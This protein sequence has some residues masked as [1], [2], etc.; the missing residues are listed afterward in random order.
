MPSHAAEAVSVGQVVTTT[1]Y[2][3]LEKHVMRLSV[4]LE[5]LGCRVTL[6]CRRSATK[7][8]EEARRNGIETADPRDLLL[9]RTAPQILHAHDGRAAALC[10]VGASHRSVFVRTQHFTHPA[11]VER[12]QLLQPAGLAFQRALNRRFAGYIAVSAAV[13]AATRA[14]GEVAAADVRVIPPGIDL[15]PL[16]STT[17]ARD[18]ASQP[19]V[20]ALGRLEAERRLDL[21]VKATPRISESC[22]GIRFVVAGDGSVGQQLRDEANDLGVGDRFEWLGWLAEPAEL[23]RRVDIFVNPTS[24]EGFGMA[25]AEAMAHGLPVVA[26]RAG[27][28][29][30]MVTPGETGL[31][32]DPENPD[33]LADAVVALARDKAQRE[34]MGRTAAGQ[35]RSRYA[36]SVVAQ[37]VLSFYRD[38]L[39]ATPRRPTAAA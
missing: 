13:D 8:R 36:S 10:A 38:L 1:A 39:E 20:G 34:H 12:H 15:P 35:A 37:E 29:V 16:G 26:A 4:E 17:V 31:L 9:R 3:G 11:T 6:I 23:Y 32:F 27:A 28:S 19:V 33:A 2:A 24:V 21:L 7:L 25:M 22:P 18:S 5:R 30:E 14:R